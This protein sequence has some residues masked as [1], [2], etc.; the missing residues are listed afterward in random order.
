VK[1]KW[2]GKCPEASPERHIFG[3]KERVRSDGGGSV[4][5]SAD[6]Q[7]HNKLQLR[8]VLLQ[9]YFTAEYC[10]CSCVM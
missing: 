3:V 1:G 9:L 10:T 8:K 2:D 5:W 7:A 4:G 6:E